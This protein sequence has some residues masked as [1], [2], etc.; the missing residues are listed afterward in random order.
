MKLHIINGSLMLLITMIY[1][2]LAIHKVGKISFEL[3]H[4]AVGSIAFFVSIIV[5]L[6]GVGT[7]A[8]M[9]TMNWNTKRLVMM[10]WVHKSAGILLLLFSQITLFYGAK[11][12]AGVH[13]AVS[14]KLM[15]VSF[16]FWVCLILVCEV[17]HQLRL[18]R[19]PEFNS[20]K[21]LV[22]HHEFLEKIK[23]GEKLVILDDMVVDISGFLL[24]HPG[25]RFALQHNIGRDISKFFYGGYTLEN[26]GS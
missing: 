24:T 4:T 6:G 7:L 17:L 10:K 13:H 5:W 23:K 15:W 20:S 14:Y 25:G 2:G 16:A 3:T 18:R 8:T 26:Q 11:L 12:Y 21:T 22:T 9:N 19:Q 1:G